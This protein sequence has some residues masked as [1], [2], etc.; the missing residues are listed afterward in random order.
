MIQVFRVSAHG[1]GKASRQRCCGALV[2]VGGC[3]Q[4]LK[5][6]EIIQFRV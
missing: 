5:G 6:R 3:L 4:T 1:C 2:E